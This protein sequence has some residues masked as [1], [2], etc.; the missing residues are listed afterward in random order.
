MDARRT[1]N[2]PERFSNAALYRQIRVSGKVACGIGISASLLRGGVVQCEPGY[3]GRKFSYGVHVLAAI[4]QKSTKT[5]MT[6]TGVP[7]RALL[8]SVSLLAILAIGC[9]DAAAPATPANDAA[10]A[11]GSDSASA[12]KSIPL[13]EVDSEGLAAALASHKVTL[14]D[15]TAVW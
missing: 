13:D 5:A 2:C 7:M 11:A 12:T 1:P 9:N 4:L 10:P 15:F 6:H 3:R 8:F 14:V